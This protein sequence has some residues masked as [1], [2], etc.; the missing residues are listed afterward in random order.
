MSEVFVVGGR[1]FGFV[2]LAV[3]GWYWCLRLFC[4]WFYSFGQVGPGISIHCS[5]HN[6]IAG[7][8][9]ALSL[10]AEQWGSLF[11]RGRGRFLISSSYRSFL[12]LHN[13]SRRFVKSQYHARLPRPKQGLYIKD[14][15]R[16]QPSD[17]HQIR[18]PPKACGPFPSTFL[19]LASPQPLA[20]MDPCG[21]GHPAAR[22]FRRR[23]SHQRLHPG[24]SKTEPCP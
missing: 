17:E 8:T 16:S 14:S 20:R 6:D 22:R 2:G 7:L 1:V 4:F 13:L 9:L 12:K 10:R 24:P 5:R 19:I 18:N 11:V 21:R 23:T 3:E 15:H